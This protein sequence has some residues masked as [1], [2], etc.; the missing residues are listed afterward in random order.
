[1]VEIVNI[2]WRQTSFRMTTLILHERFYP[3]GAEEDSEGEDILIENKQPSD[4]DSE[5]TVRK[6]TTKT[7][8]KD[9]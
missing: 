5:V 2:A 3:T 4:N 9:S 7:G 6:R 8:D 1:M